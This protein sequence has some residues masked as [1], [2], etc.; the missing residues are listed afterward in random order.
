MNTKKIPY[1][2]ALILLTTGA[3]LILGLLS[4]SGMF[5]LI[6][7]LPFAIATLVLSVA[8]EAEIYLQNIKG[9]LSKI[10]KYNYLQNQ[11]ARE[12]LLEHFP[13]N[14]NHPDC[15]PFFVNY[16]A[17]QLKLKKAP[18]K[19]EKKHIKKLLKEMEQQFALQLFS[20]SESMPISEDTNQLRIWLGQHNQAAWQ[21]DFH[22]RRRNFQMVAAFSSLSALFMGLGSTYLIMEAFSAIPWI[23][24]IPFAY[25]PFMIVPMAV[26]AG[27][28]YGLLTYNTVT[29]L[30][31]NDTITNWFTRVH[32]HF[33]QEGFS[34]RNLFMASMS[35]LL[36]GL[37][38]ALT[39]CTAG[40]WWT[41]A[42]NAR[43]LFDWMG[44]MPKFVMG[45]INPLITGLSALGFNI[46]NTAESIEE[47]DKSIYT[48]K[49]NSSTS[50]YDSIKKTWNGLWENKNWLKVLNPFS[51]I[52]MLT[53]TPLRITLFMG[54]LVSIA[55][56][57]DRMPG[58]PQIWAALIAF[59]SEG[60]E[61]AHYFIGRGHSGKNA[62]QQETE[63]INA[64]T[65]RMLQKRLGEQGGH[66]HELDIPAKILFTLA[67]PLDILASKWNAMAAWLIPVN[68]EKKPQPVEAVADNPPPELNLALSEN[69]RS[70][71]TV[72]LIEKHIQKHLNNVWIGTDTAE[73]KEIALRALQQE[74]RRADAKDLD[75][76]L[77]SAKTNSVY[78]QHRLFAPKD[79]K[80]T[81]Q[82]FVEELS[83]R[84]T[85][86]G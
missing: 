46:Q 47:L 69:W 42:T 11:L 12:F 86:A 3:S 21:A 4:F 54:H 61:D 34:A 39:V 58:I 18:N 20:D 43:P 9:A 22:K 36:V 77:T 60:F 2:L 37:A 82:I 66:S 65:Q 30:I 6:P 10:F 62:K 25:W 74:I 56:T 17:L 19:T 70:E 81:T 84:V 52:K 73:K 16:A 71:H 8:Y 51:I 48:E 44:K 33:K 67:T 5:A 32:T 68:K 24:V 41:I 72:S 15:P 27:A 63:D 23:A 76:I 79:E 50:I 26:I 35:T 40:T 55:L 49:V 28:A 85:L 1:N 78:N 57:A 38:I 13:K 7:V 45:V 80:T 31:S 59:I 64:F 83:Q 75:G 29:D 14:I 53:I